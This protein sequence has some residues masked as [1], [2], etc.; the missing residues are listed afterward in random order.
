MDNNLLKADDYCV[1]TFGSTSHAIK[2]EAMLKKIQA[3][4]IMMPTLREI[5]TSCGLS[6]K[7]NPTNVDE[8]HENL[9][10][11]K[12]AVESVYH[13]EK[14]NGKVHLEKLLIN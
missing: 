7:I 10:N 8:Y 1:L 6:V 5:S 2:A 12:V 14:K 3:E 13:V 11:N 9:I 4:F